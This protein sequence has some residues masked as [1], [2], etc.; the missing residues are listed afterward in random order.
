MTAALACSQS[1]LPPPSPR[2]PDPHHAARLPPPPSGQ[3]PPPP[4][5]PP[6]SLAASGSAGAAP[7]LSRP[8]ASSRSSI[9]RLLRRQHLQLLYPEERLHIYPPLSCYI[10]PVP[11]PGG[12]RGRPAAHR[13]SL[14]AAGRPRAPPA[15]AS[16]CRLPAARR[17]FAPC[18]AP[19]LAPQLSHAQGVSRPAVPGTGRV[20]HVSVTCQS[21]VSHVSVTCQSR[22]SHASDTCQAVS[23]TRV[24]LHAPTCAHAR[25]RPFSVR[26]CPR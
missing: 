19:P 9:R 22:V 6:P 15:T 10:C 25:L 20:S 21:R 11:A 3:P 1:V 13:R 7:R 17:W 24:R 2:R 26:T 14:P 12:Q 8:R 5:S 16:G 4:V 23:D 18:H